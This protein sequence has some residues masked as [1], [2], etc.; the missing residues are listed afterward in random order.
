VVTPRNPWLLVAA[1]SGLVAVAAGAYGWHGLAAGA[2]AREVYTTGVHYQMWHS[3][4]LLAVAWLAESRRGTPAAR[5]IK[6]AGIAFAA[7]IVLF[8]GSLYFYGVAGDV[9]FAGAAPAGGVA[10]MAGWGC[11]AV[12]ALRKG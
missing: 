10:L 2:G 1:L 11:L 7:G 8:S 9:P 3:L 5:W 6:W 4:A 12:A